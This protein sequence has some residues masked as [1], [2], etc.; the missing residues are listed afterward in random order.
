MVS[1]GVLEALW[2][3]DPVKSV[4]WA[5]W[6]ML[7]SVTILKAIEPRLTVADK[8]ERRNNKLLGDLKVLNLQKVILEEEKAEA[9][10]VQLKAE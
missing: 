8:V 5:E 4:R 7:R 9:I 2:D 1:E 10:A 6:A 3:Y